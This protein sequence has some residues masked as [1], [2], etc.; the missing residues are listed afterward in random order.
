[1]IETEELKAAIDKIN[2][3]GCPVGMVH[4]EQIKNLCAASDKIGEK[5]DSLYD[6]FDKVVRSVDTK[7]I[8]TIIL[9]V[10][11]AIVG[12]ITLGL[13]ISDLIK[14]APLHGLP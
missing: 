6:K 2:N 5:I 3:L 12:G 13:K 10:V 11:V 9:I 1:M 7:W 8:I 4:A 14:M